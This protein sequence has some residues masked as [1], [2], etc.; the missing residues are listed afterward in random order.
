ML[1]WQG[2]RMGHSLL[3]PGGPAQVAHLPGIP[4]L[5]LV[6]WDAL[7]GHCSGGS[8]GRSWPSLT[9]TPPPPGTEV[10]H[11]SVTTMKVKAPP[12]A[13]AAVAGEGILVSVELSLPES[14]DYLKELCGAGLSPLGSEARESRLVLGLFLPAR[15]C[16]LVAGF[17]SS[18]SGVCGPK[19]NP[20]S[21]RPCCS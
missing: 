17:F 16:S 11:H 12:L 9:P 15:W 2:K 3:L 19:R 5:L 8:L 18:K 4:S 20:G 7:R 13:F 1:F 14:N 6:G 10:P 21:P